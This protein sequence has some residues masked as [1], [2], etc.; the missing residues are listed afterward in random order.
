CYRRA[1]RHWL[2]VLT[3]TVLLAVVGVQRRRV[4][5]G[6]LTLLGRVLPGRGGRGRGGGIRCQ[7]EVGS[8]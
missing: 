5:C 4:Q 2:L 3:G 6:V 7:W 1:L 8:Y